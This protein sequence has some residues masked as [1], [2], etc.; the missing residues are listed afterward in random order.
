[1]FEG[2]IRGK[3]IPRRLGGVPQ[4]CTYL[5]QTAPRKESS[6]EDKEAA[7]STKAPGAV[8]QV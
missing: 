1:M 6:F 8:Y 5:D 3:I 4:Q 2:P 7:L